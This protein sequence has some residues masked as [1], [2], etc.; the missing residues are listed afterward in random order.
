MIHSWAAI[1]RSATPLTVLLGIAKP[2][3]GAGRAAELGIE[4]RC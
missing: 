2:M 1:S 3:P 4:R